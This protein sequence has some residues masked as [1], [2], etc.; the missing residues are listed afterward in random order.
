MRGAVT[1]HRP[2]A[3]ARRSLSF[4]LRGRPHQVGLVL[5]GRQMTTAVLRARYPRDTEDEAVA[6]SA[7]PSGAASP[8]TR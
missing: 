3:G 4:V 7:A 2:L 1:R 8:P 5:A 6:A